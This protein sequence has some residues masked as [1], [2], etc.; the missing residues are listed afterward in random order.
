MRVVRIGDKPETRH[1]RVPNAIARSRMSLEAI[2]MY[3]YLLSV[4]SGWNVNFRNSRPWPNGYTT[5]RAAL[6]ELRH[7]GLVTHVVRETLSDGRFDYVIGVHR[8]PCGQVVDNTVDNTV[9]N[10]EAVCSSP[11]PANSTLRKEKK[12]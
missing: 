12:R 1:V 11:R 8:K 2:G 10:Q 3:T 5:T 4:P 7:N 6:D 9:D